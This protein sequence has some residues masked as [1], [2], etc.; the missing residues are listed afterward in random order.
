MI[1]LEIPLKHRS[2]KYRFFEMVPGIVSWGSIILLVVLIL[3]GLVLWKPVQ[4]QGLGMLIGDYEGAR[5]VHFFAMAGVVFF[6]GGARRHG[7]TRAPHVPFHVYRP[8]PD[9]CFLDRAED[10]REAEKHGDEPRRFL[11]A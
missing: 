11:P 7:V 9:A 1:N 2:R 6:R 5:Y 3:S 8:G 4:F 10:I